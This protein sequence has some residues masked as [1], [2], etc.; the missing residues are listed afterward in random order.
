MRTRLCD[1]RLRFILVLILHRSYIERGLGVGP[2]AALIQCGVFSPGVNCFAGGK[3]FARVA[4]ANVKS[5][6]PV[7]R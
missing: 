4:K 6:R 7:Q 3:R 2:L 1:L 5:M